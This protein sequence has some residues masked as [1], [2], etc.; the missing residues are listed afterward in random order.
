MP[1][2]SVMMKRFIFGFHRRV[3]CPKCTP[4]S[5]SWRMVTTAMAFDSLLCPTPSRRRGTAGAV[6]VAPWRVCF[7]LSR[8]AGA[9]RPDARQ[10]VLS[11]VLADPGPEEPPPA[12]RFSRRCAVGRTCDSRPACAGRHRSSYGRDGPDRESSPGPLTC[13]DSPGPRW[14]GRPGFPVP[15]APG[16]R[17]LLVVLVVLGLAGPAAALEVEPASGSWPLR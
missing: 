16:M 1:L 17:L 14:R 4:L 13:E 6:H 2:R 15:H 11:R 12:G 5:R 7:R 10:E 9:A 3:W 8:A